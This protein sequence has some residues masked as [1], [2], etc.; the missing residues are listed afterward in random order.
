MDAL[1]ATCALSMPSRG[2]GDGFITQ[3]RLSR[4]KG[5]AQEVALRGQ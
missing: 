5:R 2:T 3:P 1:P 4:I